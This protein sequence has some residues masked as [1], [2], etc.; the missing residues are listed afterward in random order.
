[1]EFSKTSKINPA[2]LTVG[3]SLSLSLSQHVENK[4]LRVQPQAVKPFRWFLSNL[5]PIQVDSA[6]ASI[7]QDKNLRF[8]FKMDSRQHSKWG[9]TFLFWQHTRFPPS[10][11]HGVRIDRALIEGLVI[12]PILWELL[13]RTNNT[14]A[15]HIYP[16]C[17][18][19]WVGRARKWM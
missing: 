13:W 15:A 16:S 9:L 18:D 6:H 5:R 19:K 4:W 17:W 12:P 14:S 8:V 7:E 1:M 2:G 10:K 11:A 3:E